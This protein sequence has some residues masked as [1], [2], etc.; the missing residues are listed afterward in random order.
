[1]FNF[2]FIR[3]SSLSSVLQTYNGKSK[4]E[5]DSLMPKN[6][7]HS[8]IY[9]VVEVLPFCFFPEPLHPG[10]SLT[11]L[12]RTENDFFLFILVMSSLYGY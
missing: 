5:N 4:S 10:Q 7:K 3:S 6:K 2:A 11:Y 9:F 12:K 8:L 1:M